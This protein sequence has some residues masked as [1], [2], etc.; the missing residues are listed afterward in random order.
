MIE[1]ISP[2]KLDIRVG[3]GARLGN[4]ITLSSGNNY[5]YFPS[6]WP[7]KSGFIYIKTDNVDV[8]KP[9]KINKL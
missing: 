9:F 5:I 3:G 8:N 6:V 7:G 2:Y 1:V 4:L